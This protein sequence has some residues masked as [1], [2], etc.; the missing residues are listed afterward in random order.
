[1]AAKKNKTTLLLGAAA[2]A[3]IYFLKNGTSTPANPN[4]N[5]YDEENYKG[6]V[7][8]FGPKVPTVDAGDLGVFA[9]NG[10]KIFI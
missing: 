5:P 8:A 3:A 1:M 7:D 2:L 9:I 10:T 6:P 4:V